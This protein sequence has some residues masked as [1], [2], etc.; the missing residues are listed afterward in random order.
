MKKL[1]ICALAASAAFAGT[2]GALPTYAISGTGMSTIGPGGDYLTLKDACDDVIVKGSRDASTWTF[3]IIGDTTESA[4]VF[5][6]CSITPGGKILFKPA[7]GVDATIT[8]TAAA[9]SAVLFTNFGIGAPSDAYPT[10]STGS[11]GIEIDGSNTV[12]GTTRNLSFLRSALDGGNNNAFITLIADT[13]NTIIKNCNI[14]QASTASSPATAAFGT[15]STLVSSVPLT[16]DGWLIEN[17]AIDVPSS[18]GGVGI[19][20]ND[21][22]G[23]APTN[24]GSHGFTVRNNVITARQRGFQYKYAYD[25]TVTGNTI[26]VGGTLPANVNSDNFAVSC[27]GGSGTIPANLNTISNNRIFIRNT[28]TAASTNGPTALYFQANGSSLGYEFNI[29]NNEI[30][31]ASVGARNSGLT[32]HST[33]GITFGNTGATARMYNN[34]IWIAKNTNALGDPGVATQT[35]GIGNTSGALYNW[36]LRGNVIYTNEANIPAISQTVVQSGVG[37]GFTSDYNIIYAPTGFIGRVASTTYADLTTYNGATGTDANSNSFNVVPFFNNV[38]PTIGVA[39]L[40]LVASGTYPIATWGLTP[41]AF[42][43]STVTT[44][45]AGDSRTGSANPYRGFDELPNHTAVNDW[46]ILDTE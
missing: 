15:R 7:I 18:A 12:G 11:N 34:T 28:A 44:D 21:L 1:I 17:C 46:M 39:D 35:Y 30:I 20:L 24:F 40:T 25:F 6:A 32:T 13:D 16:P 33:R 36:D 27:S 19:A 26:Q 23:T 8:F 38:T 4:N 45:Y 2:A 29:F 37:S 14:T 3:S 9:R 5:L 43:T 10:A 22:V 41:S 31:V 42:S